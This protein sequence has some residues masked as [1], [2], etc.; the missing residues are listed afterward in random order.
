M[1]RP[2][3]MLTL[4]IAAIACMQGAQASELQ[5]YDAVYKTVASGFKVNVKRR[6][7]IDDAQITISV[8]AKRLFFGMRETSVLMDMEGG[9]LSPVTYDH[10]RRGLSKKH[11]KELVFDWT[12]NTV[13]DLLKPARP[14]MA[15][16]NSTYDK[17]SYQTRMRLDLIRNPDMQHAAYNVTNGIVNRVYTF[18]RIGEE[19]IKTPLGNLRTIK[20]K[21]EGGDDDRE[22]NVWVAPDW[23]FLL[24]RIDQTKER[25]GKTERMLLKSAKIAGKKVVGL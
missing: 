2:G 22:V 15:V 6:L 23:D 19:I 18:D 21:R 7:Q 11:D 9:T 20:F 3:F 16:E 14:A 10:K 25:G 4:M 17:L 12:E 24:V 5:P 8:S 1:L 13:I